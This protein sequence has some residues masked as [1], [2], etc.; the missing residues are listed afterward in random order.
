M[1]DGLPDA[2]HDGNLV[3][4]PKDSVAQARGWRPPEIARRA[5]RR[6]AVGAAAGAAHVEAIAGRPKR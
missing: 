6:R 2:E 5:T 4:D 1:D 3:I